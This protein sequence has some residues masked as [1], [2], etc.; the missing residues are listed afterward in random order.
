MAKKKGFVV[1]K[2]SEC[3]YTQPGWLG[4]CPECG[5]WNTMEEC[6]VDPNAAGFQKKSD[7]TVAKVRPVPMSKISMQDEGRISTGNVEFDRVL[8]GGATKRSAILV[9]GE[10][11]IGK[12][13]LLIQCAAAVIAICLGGG[14]GVPGQGAC[15]ASGA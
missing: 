6:I 8:G 9:G 13:T 4:R 14:V 11:G 2:C 10:P 1:Y 12:S 15:G 3:S 5:A 7:G